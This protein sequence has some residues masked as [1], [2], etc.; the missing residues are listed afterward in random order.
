MIKV[1][2]GAFAVLNELFIITI[3]SL[4]VYLH[5]HNWVFMCKLTHIHKQKLR[6]TILV[7][8]KNSSIH[9]VRNTKGCAYSD[10]ILVKK[11]PE[12]L[13]NRAG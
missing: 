9:I 3:C 8:L 4:H 13:E 11:R 10:G 1:S 5:Y 7:H 2:P 6:E 12:I